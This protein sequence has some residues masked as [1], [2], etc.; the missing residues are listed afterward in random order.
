MEF[1]GDSCGQGEWGK[2]SE[3]GEGRV[4]GGLG[5]CGWAWVVKGK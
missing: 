3:P 5:F 2:V 4:P 1:V